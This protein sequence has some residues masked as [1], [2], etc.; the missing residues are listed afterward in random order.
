[1]LSFL[2]GLSNDLPLSLENDIADN[3]IENKPRFE[4][5]VREDHR[6]EGEGSDGGYEDEENDITLPSCG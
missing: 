5:C 4:N 1:M 3:E 6:E 2:H